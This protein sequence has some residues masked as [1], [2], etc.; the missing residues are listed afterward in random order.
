MFKIIHHST[1]CPKQNVR[2]AFHTQWLAVD[3]M[4]GVEDVDPWDHMKNAE[5]SLNIHSL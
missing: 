2:S 3:R 5:T 4:L 1:Y